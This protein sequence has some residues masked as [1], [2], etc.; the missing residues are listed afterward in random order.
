MTTTST[1]SD[2][3][4]DPRVARSRAAIIDAT[5]AMLA[6]EGFA[7]TTIEGI[8][9]RAGVAKTTV[10]RHWEDRRALLLDALDS[11]FEPSPVPDLGDLRSDLLAAMQT[12]AEGFHDSAWSRLLPA[13]IEARERDPDY[14]GV[15]ERLA[16]QRRAP[17]REVLAR[18]AAKGS[19]SDD[20]DPDDAVATLVGSLLY[21]RL[22]LNEPTDDRAVERLVDLV[23]PGLIPRGEHHR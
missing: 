3:T 13:M 22:A 18:A 19:L 5:V 11:L 1:T 2:P 9:R 12:L 14:D 17:L 16:R 10:Y 15:H 20:V 23:L 6:E 4:V 21:R 8:A 7:N